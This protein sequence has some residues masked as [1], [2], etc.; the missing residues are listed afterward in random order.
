MNETLIKELIRYKLN[1]ADVIVGSLPAHMSEGIRKTG[2][3]ILEGINES[4]SER[5]EGNVSKSKH[6]DKLNNVPIE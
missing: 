3:I 6:P 2:R 1:M 5:K 4:C